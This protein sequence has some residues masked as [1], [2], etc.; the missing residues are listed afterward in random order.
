MRFRSPPFTPTAL[1]GF[2]STGWRSGSSPCFT[3]TAA[4]LPTAW[5]L[6][7][8]MSSRNW[9]TKRGRVPVCLSGIRTGDA[10]WHGLQCKR[11]EFLRVILG[12][13]YVDMTLENIES[14]DPMAVY[15]QK[16]EFEMSLGITLNNLWVSFLTFV[17]GAFFTIGS[18]AVL[19]RNGIMLGSFQ[20]FFIERD[21]FWESFLTVWVHGTLEISAIIIAGAA[22]ITMGRGWSSPAPTTACRLFRNQPGGASKSWLALRPLSLWRASL[23][24]T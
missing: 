20:Y 23:R 14:G 4:P 2:T 1:S 16:G 8:R 12:D 22:G 6:S 11:P 19:V 18:I 7:G 13:S 5:L 24:G 21:L 10:D 3:A 17:T 9:C 15:K